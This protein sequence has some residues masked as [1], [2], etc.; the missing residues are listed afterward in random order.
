MSINSYLDGIASKLI[1]RDDAKSAID[2]SVSVFKIR[3]ANKSQ[4]PK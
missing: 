3:P 2:N 1:I 4:A